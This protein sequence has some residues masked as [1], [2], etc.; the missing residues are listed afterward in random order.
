MS[1]E[2]RSSCLRLPRP[3]WV[4]TGVHRRHIRVSK[5]CFLCMASVAIG[6]RGV[7][8][9]LMVLAC[10]LR[11]EPSQAHSTELV[12]RL[13]PIDVPGVIEITRIV[14]PDLALLDAGSITHEI[15]PDERH[16][17]LVTRRQDLALNRNVYKL[18]LFDTQTLLGGVHARHLPTE[19]RV[20]VEAKSDSNYVFEH[21]VRSA[22]WLSNSEIIF[23]GEFDDRPAQ[24]FI[25]DIESGRLEQ[26][27][28]HANSVL[29][30]DYEPRSHTVVYVAR[31]P[32]ENHH[33]QAASFVAGNSTL[34]RILFPD[35]LSKQQI[36]YQYY[37]SIVGQ[38]GSTK[39]LGEPFRMAN[40][41]PSISISPNARWA[42]ARR[43]PKNFA[44]STRFADVYPAL[45]SMLYGDLGDDEDPESLA[46]EDDS[47]WVMQ[48]R[49]FDVHSGEELPG[50]D[51]PDA[52]I[53]QERPYA[54]W[55]PGGESVVIANTYLPLEGGGEAERRRRAVTPALIEYWPSTGRFARIT[56]LASGRG[57]FQ[58][59]FTD[60]ARP[61]F[62]SLKEKGAVR[63]FRKRNA[64]WV[65]VE[66]SSVSGRVRGRLHLVQSVDEAPNVVVR[67]PDGHDVRV[68]DLNPQLRHK[69]LGRMQPYTWHDKSGREWHGGLL[70]PSSFDRTRRYPLVIQL[71]GFRG[72]QFYVD[73]IRQIS[74]AMAGRAY[75]REGILVLAG[76]DR[77]GGRDE[78]EELFEH[79]D[80]IKSAID[81][82]SADGTVD[83][84]RVGIVGFSNRGSAVQHIITF[85]D[86]R[87][88]AATIA[89]SA[90]NSLFTAT[91]WAYGLPKPG[92]LGIERRF[93]A[94][95]WGESADVWARR[96]PSF[97]TDCIEAA[98]RYEVYNLYVFPDWI[99][100]ALLRR[101]YKPVELVVFPRGT[102]Q[103]R[104][105]RERFDSL[106][107]NVDWFRFW[108]KD[109]ED[110]DPAKAEQYERWR[111]MKAR[112]PQVG[113]R[114]ECALTQ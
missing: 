28:Q 51:A 40:L 17:F 96:D 94:K 104:R 10:L 61:G 93:K 77:G 9:L 46:T 112:A 62:L 110:P 4:T 14:Q 52:T 80:G 48:P 70:V 59:L 56:D 45:R 76:P 75:L 92:P 78:R 30:Y 37:R 16:L 108:L 19:G 31:E 27:T 54:Q 102:H 15:S 57:S 42:I 33:M 41:P 85:A 35:E 6:C 21:A 66:P 29:S 114:A 106:Q 18:L 1:A 50:L 90:T 34:A 91:A 89:D 12:G 44:E 73:G 97:Y 32:A 98:V 63:A 101:Q 60:S 68:T 103:L 99:P 95:P 69:D 22:K 100:Y 81:A 7:I 105:P 38:E 113:R 23:L 13:Q 11:I 3:A 20:L 79:A 58:G 67:M 72:D 25:V 5:Y 36:F 64:T 107:G 83:P 109:E 87:I 111:R 8:G 2:D 53:G 88:R 86:L 24:V 43:V 65:Q 84:T 71:G 26:L 47:F 55:M 39:P 49:I 82:L 74:S